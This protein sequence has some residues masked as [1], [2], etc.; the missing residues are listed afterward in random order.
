[1]LPGAPTHSLDQLLVSGAAIESIAFESEDP[2]AVLKVLSELRLK[3]CENQSYP[4]VLSRILGITP[5]PREE[6]HG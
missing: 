3:D 1:L 6:D 4:L 2:Q 5:L